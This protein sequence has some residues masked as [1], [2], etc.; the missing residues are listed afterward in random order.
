VGTAAAETASAAP[1]TVTTEA[2][3]DVSGPETPEAP[4]QA[5]AEAAETVGG[6][7]RPAAPEPPAEAGPDAAPATPAPAQDAD[8]ESDERVR[9]AEGIAFDPTLDE[10][11]PRAEVPRSELR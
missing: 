7:T 8:D 11:S 3:P 10:A 9:K 4:A 6:G 1:D 2:G 5:A